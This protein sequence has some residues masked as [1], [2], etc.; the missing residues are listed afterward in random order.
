MP[1]MPPSCLLHAPLFALPLVP[2]AGAKHEAC[3]CGILEAQRRTWAEFLWPRTTGQHIRAAP[4]GASDG[5]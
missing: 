2:P 3:A 4:E 5:S 1:F